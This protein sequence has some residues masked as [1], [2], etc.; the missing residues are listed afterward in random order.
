M[1]HSDVLSLFAS[2]YWANKQVFATAAQLTPA[3]FAAPAHL[4][5]GSVR[6][7][8]AHLVSAEWTWRM[9]CEE[10]ISPSAMLA[11]EAFARE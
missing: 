9:R 11:D 4:S 8:L 1:S 10:G 6:G 3:Q 7:T 5:H 2:N